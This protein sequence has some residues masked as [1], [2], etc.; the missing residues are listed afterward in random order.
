MYVAFIMCIY[1]FIWAQDVEKVIVTSD[2]DGKMIK[3]EK[4]VSVDVMKNGDS[5][6]TVKIVTEENGEKTVMEW[7]DN[8][9]IPADIQ[10]QLDEQG[11]DVHV[12]SGEGGDDREIEI[13][14]DDRSDEVIEIEWDGEGEMPAALRE[15]NEEYGVDIEEYLDGEEGEKKIVMVKKHVTDIERGP[16][17]RVRK[18]EKSKYKTI[19]IDEDG[20]EEVIEWEGDDMPHGAMQKEGKRRAHRVMK[21]KSED[22]NDF[23]FFGDGARESK[24]L[25]KAYMGA[26]I[27]SD[28]DAGVAVLD[29]MKDGPADKAKLKKGDIIKRVNGA[30]TR[31]MED[32]LDL[33]NFFEP[34]DE[35]KVQIV[36]DGKEKEVKLELGTRPD[37]FR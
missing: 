30:R 33:L 5:E 34:G 25:S 10:R 3:Q 2:G 16:E 7:N 6:R 17:V 37:H 27:E 23:T 28:D 31:T 29:L 24:R 15:M 22:G 32:L 21:W 1:S 12:L 11:I 19:T 20:N 9:E 13:V 35:V 18:K 4:I 26:H 8:G 36:R 14:V